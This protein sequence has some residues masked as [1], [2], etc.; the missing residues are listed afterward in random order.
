MLKNRFRIYLFVQAFAVLGVVLS[1]RLIPDKKW[2]SV[3]ASN[4]F[5]WSSVGILYS[6]AWMHRAQKKILVIVG[7]GLFLGLFVLP[8]MG[9]RLLNWDMEFGQVT[10]LGVTGAQMHQFSNYAF[11]LMLVTYFV[12]SFKENKKGL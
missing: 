7:T 5:L 6:E 2:A 10:L 4:L 8:V 12:E 3:V 11:M 9:M 1:F